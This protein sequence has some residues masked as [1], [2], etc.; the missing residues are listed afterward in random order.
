MS[1]STNEA[2]AML[3]EIFGDDCPL[4]DD[5]TWERESRERDERI[6]LQAAIDKVAPWVVRAESEDGR[7]QMLLGRHITREEA[8]TAA[9]LLRDRHIQIIHR[10]PDGEIACE[11]GY[12]RNDGQIVAVDPD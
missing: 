8:L 1:E 10:S 12:V 2:R 4:P 7:D 3:T 9:R 6:A 5:E 11:A